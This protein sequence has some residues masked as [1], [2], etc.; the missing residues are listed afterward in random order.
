MTDDELT[1]TRFRFAVLLWVL[2]AVGYAAW[3]LLK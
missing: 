2:V 3:W 1:T